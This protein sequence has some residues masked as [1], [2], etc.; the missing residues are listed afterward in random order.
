VHSMFDALLAILLSRS[1]YLRIADDSLAAFEVVAYQSKFRRDL[2]QSAAWICAAALTA[3][4]VAFLAGRISPSARFDSVKTMLGVGTVLTVSPT[5]FILANP[6]PS[7]KGRLDEKLRPF[8]FKVL[9]F[10]GIVLLLTGS[11]S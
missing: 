4:F 9:F 11:L 5:W 3:L 6:N 10:P 1:R 7:W 2:W 8:C